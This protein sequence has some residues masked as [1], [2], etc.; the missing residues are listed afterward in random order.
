MIQ[1]KLSTQNI[2]ETMR[3]IEEKWDSLFPDVPFSYS[4][5]DREFGALY[6]SEVRLGNSLQLLALLS[7]MI[8]AL[9]LFGQAF[10]LA[11]EKSREIGIRKVIGA[12]VPGLIVSLSW[13]FLKLVLVANLLALPIGI[14]LMNQWLNDYAFRI[15]M[16]L[17]LPPLIM[18]FTGAFT[19]LVILFHTYQTA[20]INPTK[21]LAQ[22]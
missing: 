10:M 20:S 5:I 4:F 11:F 1:M 9:G 18:V 7:I 17:L 2:R 19:V 15:E 16:P 22:E 3:H 8:A 6:D 12:S 14:Y 21:V 13:K